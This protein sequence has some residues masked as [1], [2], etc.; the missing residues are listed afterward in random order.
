MILQ[1]NQAV[2]NAVRDVAQTGSALKELGERTA[3]QQRKLSAVQFSLESASAQYSRG[4]TDRLQVEQARE[5]AIQ[6]QLAMLQLTVQS[7][8]NAIVLTK[9]LGGGYQS[10]GAVDSSGP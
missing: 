8:Q 6:Q 10:M 4:L 5:S 7:L 1:Y 9:T 2:L 3:M